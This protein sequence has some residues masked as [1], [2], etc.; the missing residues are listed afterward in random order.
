M[1]S[2]YNN[3]DYIY[4]GLNK[5]NWATYIQETYS[6]ASRT[7]SVNP[8]HSYEN[9]K[10]QYRYN[11]DCSS[12]MASENIDFMFCF[13]FIRL[14]ILQTETSSDLPPQQNMSEWTNFLSDI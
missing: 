2:S 1:S 8:Q 13:Q 14:A 3:L 6:A 7:V 9:S 12:Q 5:R 4:K 10:I 11:R